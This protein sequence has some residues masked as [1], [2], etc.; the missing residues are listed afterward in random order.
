M[1]ISNTI[2]TLA[3]KLG[4]LLLQKQLHL[5]TAES[6]TGGGV[7]YALTAIPGSSQW[8]ECGFVTY[9]NDS[10]KDLLSVSDKTLQ[11][12]GAV[13]AETAKEMAEGAIRK[14]LG[15]TS[16]AITG[17]A[18]PD[19]G[20]ADKPV[21]TVWFGWASDFFPTKTALKTFQGE[22]QAIREQAI[23][24]AL[25]GLVELLEGEGTKPNTAKSAQR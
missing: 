9:S 16:V 17:I 11:T 18:G 5:V 20:S 15:N 8:F 21:G 10:K 1:T 24:Y 3:E 23:Q 6:C 13:S 7:A 4:K 2:A 25:S 19:G 14:S 22:R 12:Y